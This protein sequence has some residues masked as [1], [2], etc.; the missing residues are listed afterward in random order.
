MK[1][2]YRHESIAELGLIRGLLE[3]SGIDCLVKNEQLTGALGEI[4]VFECEP[5]L[6][7]IRDQDEQRALAIIER[8][9]ASWDGAPEWVC[10]HCGERNEGQF[11]V[12]WHCSEPDTSVP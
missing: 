10:R 3:H 9:L 2:V 6:W 11:G 8:H 5:E 7:V 1:K 12:C 4:P